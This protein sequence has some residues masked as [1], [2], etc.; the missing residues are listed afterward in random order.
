MTAVTDQA[1]RFASLGVICILILFASL[2]TSESALPNDS[3]E[4]LSAYARAMNGCRAGYLADRSLL[5][6]LLGSGQTIEGNCSCA[7][8]AL[9]ARKDASEIAYLARNGLKPND[10]PEFN[11]LMGMCSGAGVR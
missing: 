2:L 9:I 11:Q 5:L 7:T 4:N 8:A 1:P 10:L 3:G 6:S